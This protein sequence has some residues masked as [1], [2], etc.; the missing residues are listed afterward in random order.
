MSYPCCSSYTQRAWSCSG[1]QEVG[2]SPLVAFYR[3]KE[4]TTGRYYV[5]QN[6]KIRGLHVD[7]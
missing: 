1:D 3:G 7:P 5:P 4:I 6:S 2:C